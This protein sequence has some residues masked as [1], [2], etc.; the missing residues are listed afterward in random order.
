MLIYSVQA[1]YE[2]NETCKPTFEMIAA[3]SLSTPCKLR[4]YFPWPDVLITQ[5]KKV[6]TDICSLNILIWLFAG[7]FDS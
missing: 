3:E 1:I 4:L 7:I 2:G 6:S 5:N